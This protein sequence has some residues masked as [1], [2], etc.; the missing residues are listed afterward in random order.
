MKT[1]QEYLTRLHNFAF[2]GRH[3][4]LPR[5]LVQQD[6]LTSDSKFMKYKN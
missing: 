1:R 2:I 6:S 3:Y 5:I 4:S